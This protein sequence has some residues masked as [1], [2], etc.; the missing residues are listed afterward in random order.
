MALVGM[1]DDV[2]LFLRAGDIFALPSAYEVVLLA[3]GTRLRRRR[4]GVSMAAGLR[5][6]G[7][8]P[9]RQGSRLDEDA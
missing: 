1:Q 9:R 6:F 5:R 3:D 8:L 7:G 4:T 2:R